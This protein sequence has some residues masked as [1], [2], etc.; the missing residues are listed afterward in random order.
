MR[1]RSLWSADASYLSLVFFVVI[2]MASVAL[3]NGMDAAKPAA[4][5]IISVVFSCLLFAVALCAYLY[6][7]H[8]QQQELVVVDLIFDKKAAQRIEEIQRFFEIDADAATAK[9]LDWLYRVMVWSRE[10][11]ELVIHDPQTG[12]DKTLDWTA[13]D[14]DDWDRANLD[15]DE[16]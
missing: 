1:L 11:K 3:L 8:A 15:C 9:G 16:T 7:R 6:L 12:I 10:G 14:H 5:W 13:K 2:A 4:D